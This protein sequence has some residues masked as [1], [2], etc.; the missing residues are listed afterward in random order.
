MKL[1]SLFLTLLFSIAALS[2]SAAD[3][4]SVGFCDNTAS[5]GDTR[6]VIEGDAPY[7]YHAAILL[8]ADDLARF[9]NGKFAGVN[10]GLQNNFGIT[11]VKV[12]IRSE[13]DGADLVSVE[14]SSG[15]KSG[16]NH[17]LFDTPFAIAAGTSY[18]VGYTIANKVPTT[19]IGLQKSINH[20]GAHYLKLGDG[21][22]T[23]KADGY[24]AV[25]LEALVEADNLP[26]NNVSLLSASL[27]LDYIAKD[28]PLSLSYRVKNSG[29]KTLTSF[30]ITLE[31][32]SKGVSDSHTVNCNLVYGKAAG[33][34]QD[35]T[36][37]N[38]VDGNYNFT[39]RL[40][41]PNNVE[42]DFIGDNEIILPTVE[43]S[44]KIFAR[45]VVVE[46][47][48]TENC[49]N[50]PRAI[51]ALKQAHNAL[52]AEQQ[53]RLVIVCHH[54]GY[55]T[56]NFTQQCDNSYVSLYGDRTFAPAYMVDRLSSGSTPVQSVPDAQGIIREIKKR[57]EVPSNYNLE[58]YGRHDEST[59]TIT[60]NIDMMKAL[61]YLDNPKL[62]VY[63][64]E[65]EVLASNN[66]SGQKGGAVPFYHSHVIRA[67]NST[68]GADIVW[69]E[70]ASSAYSCTLEYADGCK[71]QDMEIVAMITNYDADNINNMEVG[72]A[73]KVR[74]SDLKLRGENPDEPENPDPD[75]GVAVG[76]VDADAPVVYADN[77]AICVEGTFDTITVYDLSG[78]KV[79]NH[80]LN[81]G[82]YIFRILTGD[83]IHTGKVIVR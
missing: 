47:F 73:A 9:S 31:D 6:L 33:L 81:S 3:Y 10:V 19:Y 83:L 82:I 56:D 67:Y 54:S 20:E 58:I 28:M 57:Q 72:N 65:D 66:G 34:T 7:L 23:D 2:L 49:P 26:Q 25:T 64:L 52:S 74:L 45:T 11:G 16:W 77:G 24:G 27:A 17:I 43:Y 69:D 63:L 29:L 40:E 62:V 53:A 51:T 13:L 32:K 14:K 18:Y 70:N 41:L 4:V 36:F 39:V 22:W 8:K 21:S 75:P 60:L 12:W 59:R 5:I 71:V 79:N 37:A 50:C 55:G 61:S 68:W 46:E 48:T 44:S 76:N 1:K 78:R 42:D 15:L 30:K 35:F 80:S 38:L